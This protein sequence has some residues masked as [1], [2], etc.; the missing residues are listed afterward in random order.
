MG[1]TRNHPNGTGISPDPHDLDTYR[2]ANADLAQLRVPVLLHGDN[3]HERLFVAGL[4]GTGNSMTDDSPDNWSAVAKIAKQIRDIHNSGENRIAGGYVEGTYTQNG[5]LN[6]PKRLLDGAF[7]ITF[8]NRVE[9]AYF[10]LCVQ[11][12]AWLEEDPQAQIRVA[13]VGFSR[14]AEE[15]AALERMIHERG[16]RNPEGADYKVDKE[17]LITRIE[18]ADQPPLVPPGQTLQAALLFDPVSTGVKEHDRSLPSSTVSTFQLT[19][20]DEKSNLFKASDHIPPGFSEDQRNLNATVG[21]AHGDVGNTHPNGG[22]GARSFNLGVDFL[23]RLS[24]QPYLQKQAVPDDPALSV[25]HQPSR[26]LLD[27]FGTSGYDK[28]GLRDRN[29]DQSPQPGIQQKDPIS[30]ELERKLDRRTAPAPTGSTPE[31]TF[32]D[33]L[34]ERLSR[35]AF[36]KDD[37]AMSAAVG[38]Y[39]RSPAG[40]QFQA[41]V[42]QQRQALDAQE[43]QQQAATMREPQAM[44]L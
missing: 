3:P 22:L 37:K 21:G 9:T 25:V 23:N 10:Q 35:G 34:F 40:E 28:D 5:V 8:E 38:D 29:S 43:L 44:S 13:G 18:Y 20:E 1:T 7:G 39:L 6:T 2:Q 17:K 11:A 32:V 12:K 31:Q 27:L 36:E 15:V 30:P 26:G 33:S 42:A 24:D 4:D 16:I 41:D 14:G 19:A